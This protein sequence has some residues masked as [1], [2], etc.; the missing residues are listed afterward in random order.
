MPFLKEFLTSLNHPPTLLEVGVDTGASFIT[1]STFL[2]RTRPEFV[3]VGIDI[4]IQDAV[5]VMLQNLDRDENKQR[6]ILAQGNSLDLLPTL[7]AQNAKFDLLMIDGDHNYHTVK[8]EMTHV[9]ALLAPGGVVV[10][11]DYDGRWSDKDLWYAERAGY[12]NVKDATQRV[13]TEKHGVKIAVD[14]WLSVNTG[15]ESAKLLAG[16]PILLRRKT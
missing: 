13:E 1:L 10:I 3:A 9:D 7:T 16:E 8:N 15:W 2:A 14:E 4:K 5:V 6:V 12:E 11:D